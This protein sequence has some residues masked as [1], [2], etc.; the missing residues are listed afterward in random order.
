MTPNDAQRPGRDPEGRFLATGDGPARGYSWPPFKPG[1]TAAQKHGARSRNPEN[2]KG[3]GPI[4]STLEAEVVEVAPWLANP[5]HAAA[6]R[7]WAICEARAHL[8]RTWLADKG[9]LDEEG[10][11]RPAT[12]LLATLDS[13]AE[14]A[15][16]RLGL[17]PLALAKLLATFGA[18]ERVGAGDGDTLAQ[19]R[20]EGRRLLEA[21]ASADPPTAPP[22]A[23][24][25]HQ[26]RPDGSD[27]ADAAGQPSH[28]T[29]NESQSGYAE[30]RC[31]DCD[32]EL[33]RADDDSGRCRECR[34]AAVPDREDE[35]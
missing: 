11:P 10:T 16:D 20:A 24:R 8:V 22:E 7:S 12:N 31:D 6:V 26:E 27:V 5:V 13:Q 3:W 30:R 28:L 4:A 2:P 14:R 25:S 32:E 18:A 21:R 33:S 19:L 15:R 35:T 1:D 9:E 17:S 34:A 23:L 29:E